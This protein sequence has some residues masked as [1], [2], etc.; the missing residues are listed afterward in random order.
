MKFW[1]TLVVLLIA[2]GVMSTAA[3]ETPAVMDG[4]PPSAESQVTKKNQRN[5]P[6]SQWAFQNFGA[7][8]NTVMVPRAGEI[9]HFP[10]DESRLGSFEVDGKSLA[11]VFEANAADAL[12]V[13]HGDTLVHESYWNGM[14]PHRQHI[15]YSMTKSLVSSIAGLLV[16]SGQL[17]LTKSP[18]DYI[19]ELKGSAFDRVTVQQVLDHASGLAFEENYVDPKS[20]FF[21]YYAPAL[22]LGYLRG[23]ADLQPGESD[24]YGVYDFLTKFVQPDPETPPGY[25]FDY[26]SA[27]ADV[28][29]WLVSRLMDK[30]LNDVIRDEVWAK[31]GTEHDAFIAVDRAYIP[32][33]TGGYNATARD[34]ARFGVMIRDKGVFRGERVLPASWLE[35]M[36]DVKDSDRQAMTR[37]PNYS[38]ADWVA[39]QDMWWILDDQAEEFCAVGIHGQVIYVNRSTDTVMVWFS[40]QPD[41][42]S[43]LAPEF[44][45]KLDAARRAASYLAEQ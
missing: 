35:H 25:R 43:T 14:D 27:N 31:L 29:G 4:F 28:L 9:H 15:W 3:S 32:V 2:G 22:N 44:P 13:I 11:D 1:Q 20:D 26:N 17:D 18:S 21:L 39:Y 16:E 38:Q 37:N 33:A 12:V 5:W 40:S 30:P 36:V 7:P 6:Y 34:A 10:R 8:N 42:A 45:I 24:I 23:A 19:P 41:A